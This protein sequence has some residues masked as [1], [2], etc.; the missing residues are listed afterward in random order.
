MAL[1]AFNRSSSLPS[2]LLPFILP[3]SSPFMKSKK[4]LPAGRS[5]GL[6]SNLGSDVRMKSEAIAQMPLNPIVRV[7]H[8]TTFLEM[9]IF[10][11]SF[12]TT[13]GSAVHADFLTDRELVFLQ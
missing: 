9:N 10:I 8:A 3:A 4:V 12:R 13:L 1:P 2:C 7:T 5:I 6:V 11:R